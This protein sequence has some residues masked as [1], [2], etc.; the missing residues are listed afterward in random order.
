MKFNIISYI[1]AQ[2][3][4][5]GM[6]EEEVASVIG[7]P[8]IK[9]TDHFGQPDHDYGFCSVGYDKAT[10]QA[11]H[12]GFLPSAEIYYQDID[13]FHNPEAFN[14]LIAADKEPYQFVGFIVLLNLGITLSGFHDGDESQLAVNVFE[15]GLYDEFRSQFILFRGL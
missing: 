10:L 6:T 15:K 9:I 4:R 14:L 2:P 11:I 5:F 7:P 1:G 8:A 12:F 3:L 13:I